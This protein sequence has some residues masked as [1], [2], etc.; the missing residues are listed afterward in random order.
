MQGLSPAR[1]GLKSVEGKIQCP[2]RA[3]GANCDSGYYSFLPC[4]AIVTMQY[5]LPRY[6]IVPRILFLN[7]GANAMSK[8]KDTKKMTKK[9]PAKTPKEKKELKKLKKEEQKRQ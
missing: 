6:R 9:E 3:G 5:W 7:D 1:A 4:S 2:L 8:S